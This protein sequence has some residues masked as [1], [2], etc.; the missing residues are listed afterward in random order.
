MG[1]LADDPL[2]AACYIQGMNLMINGHPREFTDLEA[3][4]TVQDL[5]NALGLKLD[6]VAVEHRG[7]IVSR[8]SWAQTAITDGDKLEIVHFVGGGRRE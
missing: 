2:S 6:R 5:L 8:T 1:A 4:S 7:E 3:G